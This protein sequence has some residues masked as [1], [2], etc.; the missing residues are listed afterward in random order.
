VRAER[1]QHALAV[2][3]SGVHECRHLCLLAGPRP[4]PGHD[5]ADVPQAEALPR[6]AA[7]HHGILFAESDGERQEGRSDHLESHRTAEIV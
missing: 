2:R 5:V 4:V 6:R 1:H 3:A 7:E